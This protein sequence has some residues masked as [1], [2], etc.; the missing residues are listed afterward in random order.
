MRNNFKLPVRVC[1]NVELLTFANLN[2]KVRNE[3]I[4]PDFEVRVR[5]PDDSSISGGTSVK[6]QIADR[7]QTC[8][9]RCAS[10]ATTTTAGWERRATLSTTTAADRRGSGATSSSAG[11]NKCRCTR[12]QASSGDRRGI[13]L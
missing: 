4:G 1:I 6:G 12:V 8:R 11:G 3:P 10:A 9:R 2:I 7:R 13:T 5:L